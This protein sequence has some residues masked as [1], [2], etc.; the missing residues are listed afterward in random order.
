M[1]TVIRLVNFRPGVSFSEFL[2]SS[3]VCEYSLR[4]DERHDERGGK[5]RSGVGRRRETKDERFQ[6]CF[7]GF[8]ILTRRRSGVK[9]GL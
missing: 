8:M 2:A 7:R 4:G 3:S 1:E 6:R 5:Q 9:N